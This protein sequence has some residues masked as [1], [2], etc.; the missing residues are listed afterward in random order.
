MHGRIAGSQG[1][2]AEAKNERFVAFSAASELDDDDD[3]DEGA[4]DEDDDQEAV[5]TDN[6]AKHS[7]TG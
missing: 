6:D 2:V 1:G 4:S 3:D 5:A 7:R